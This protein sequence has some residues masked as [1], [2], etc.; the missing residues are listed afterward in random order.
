MVELEDI[1]LWFLY[2]KAEV[3]HFSREA[4]GVEYRGKLVH[5]EMTVTS[6]NQRKWP[7]MML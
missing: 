4:S 5:W 3:R 7:L 6:L 1:Y 2:F